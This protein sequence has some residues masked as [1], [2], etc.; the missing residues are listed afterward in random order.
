MLAIEPAQFPVD[1]PL[2]QTLWREYSES[3]GIDLSF[4]DFEAELAGLPGKYAPPRGRLLLARRGAQDLGCV[5][6]RPLSVDTCEMKRLYVRPAARGEQLGRRLA[7]RI[8]DEAR[9][10]GYRRICLDTLPSM[11]AAV[12]LYTSMGFRPIEPYVF[13]PI[14]GAMFLGRELSATP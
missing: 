6:L 12:G 13:N 1:L 14:P 5:A 10:A 9:A 2:V 4:Q 3:L 11:A 7:E 8:C